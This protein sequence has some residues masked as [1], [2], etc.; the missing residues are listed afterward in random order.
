MRRSIEMWRKTFW[1]AMAFLGMSLL[2][3]ELGAGA[4]SV[5]VGIA[6][7]LVG[8]VSFGR[9]IASPWSRQPRVH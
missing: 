3:S 6:A 9:L 4:L 1:I 5:Y 2:A 8:S 7:V